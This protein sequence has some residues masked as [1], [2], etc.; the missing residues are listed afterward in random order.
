MFA[1]ISDCK[2]GIIVFF[3]SF[4]LFEG[5]FII[6]ISYNGFKYNSGKSLRT[7]V[8][9]NLKSMQ[10]TVFLDTFPSTAV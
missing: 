3:Y 6:L 2:E 4:N 9:V 7:I 10:I 8:N 5:P 1:L